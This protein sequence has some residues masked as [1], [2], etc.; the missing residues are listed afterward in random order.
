MEEKNKKKWLQPQ[1]TVLVRR[2]PEEGI[3]DGCKTAPL[4]C[5]NT[6]LHDRCSR[7]P[8]GECEAT[9]YAVTES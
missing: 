5:G 1:L 7:R 9:C 2:K 4:G 6:A 8:S 3:L